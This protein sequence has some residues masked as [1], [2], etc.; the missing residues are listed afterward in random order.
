MT[1]VA[2]GQGTLNFVGERESQH[3]AACVSLDLTTSRSRTGEIHSVLNR[4]TALQRFLFLD[5]DVLCY[6]SKPPTA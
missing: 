3:R 5:S 2:K 1:S 6:F 4:S